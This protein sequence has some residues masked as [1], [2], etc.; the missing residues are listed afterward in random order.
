MANWCS[1]S[2]S[3]CSENKELLQTICDA[4]N[5]CASMKEPLIPKSSPNWVGNVFKKLGIDADTERTFWSEA[6]IEDGV[7]KFFE[8]SAWSRGNAI[9]SLQDHYLI[10]DNEDDELCV[11]FVSANLWQ[12]I[13]ETNDESG[14]FYPERYFWYGDDGDERFNTFEEL[15]EA[16]QDFLDVDTDFK[17]VDEINEALEEAEEEFGSQHIYEIEFTNLE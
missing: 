3:V 12:G 10:E 2:Y 14:E 1:T 4:I 11:Y 15:K 16:V 7:L 13:Y 6:R 17:N 9:I 8:S 5:E